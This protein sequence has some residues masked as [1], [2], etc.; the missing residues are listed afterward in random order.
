[1]RHVVERDAADGRSA[2]GSF[3]TR[4]YVMRPS[5]I[6]HLS[7]P[8]QPSHILTLARR[9]AEAR[10]RELVDEAKN[11]LDLFPNLRDAYDPEEL[12]ISFII[13]AGAGRPTKVL[14]RRKIDA[15]ARKA[16]SERMKKYWAARR[17]AEKS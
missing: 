8:K 4:P 3:W 13:K 2:G 6:L 11:L 16:I 10:F 12:P 7:M 15:A 17:K 9:G 5:D 1:M 14:R